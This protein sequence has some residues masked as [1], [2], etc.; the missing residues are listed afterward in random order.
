MTDSIRMWTFSVCSA[1]VG[2]SIAYLILPKGRFDKVLRWTLALFFLCALLS[3]L[4]AGELDLTWDGIAPA[5][6][7][8][9]SGSLDREMERQIQTLFA[10]HIE[11]AVEEHLLQ[12]GCPVEEIVVSVHAGEDDR[13]YIAQ[14]AIQLDT[15]SS[16]PIAAPQ[17]EALEKSIQDTFG[18]LPVITTT[19]TGGETD[20]ETDG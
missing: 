7:T 5:Q 20:G 9:D 12:A 15:A 10:E 4:A 17:L 18:V 19:D 8:S 6:E 1:A 3:P 2:G 13:I 11:R 16:G 14:I